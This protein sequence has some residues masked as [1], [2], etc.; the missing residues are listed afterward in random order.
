MELKDV[1]SVAGKPGLHKIIGKGA[2]GLVLESLDG[3]AKRT[4]TPLSQ[5]V[6]ILEDISVYTVDGDVKLAEIFIKMDE[7]DKVGKF[8]LLTKDAS[9]EAIK[10]W[11]EA[12]VPNFDKERVYN[13]DIQKMSN[14]F[15]LLKGKVD[16]NAKPESEETEKSDKAETKSKTIKPVKK[17][18][19]KAKPS[20]GVTKTAITSRKMS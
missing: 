11:F 3:T 16:F 13:S 14:W 6:S 10:K 12:L 15:N 8:V 19:A 2:S 4:I 18:E 5:K 17:V 20:K 1:V 7:A 9:G